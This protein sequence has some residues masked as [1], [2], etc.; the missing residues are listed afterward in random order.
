M[1]RGHPSLHQQ[2]IIVTQDIGAASCHRQR[3]GG[4][5]HMA[6]IYIYRRAPW[7]STISFIDSGGVDVEYGH[8]HTYM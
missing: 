2:A 4:E 5:F 7:W 6:H 8:A 1:G 3:G